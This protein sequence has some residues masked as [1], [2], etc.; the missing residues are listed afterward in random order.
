MT[1]HSLSP[2]M[3]GSSYMTS[4]ITSSRIARSPRAPVPR[5][6]AFLA[7][8]T[9]ASSVNLRRTFSRSKYFWYCFMMA[10]LG[11]RRI[12]ISAASSRSSSVAITGRR[13]TNSGISPYF[14]RSS[15]CA[16]ARRSPIW[17]SSRLRTSAPNPIPLFPTRLSM[18]LS[19]PT[20]APP[21]TKSTSVVSTWMN[22]WWG[23]LRPPWGGTLATVPSRIFRSACWTP[24]PDTSRVMDGFSDFRAILSI[25]SMYTIP[26][27]AR[28]T[29]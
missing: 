27:S 22:S 28:S 23:C 10:F 2:W 13:P 24:S 25:S 1:M 18:I 20:K 4:S 17:R 11:S 16:R 14:S 26:R 9:T 19:S 12:L 3:E 21:Q 6:R 15:G 7:M 8:A 29:S 5:F